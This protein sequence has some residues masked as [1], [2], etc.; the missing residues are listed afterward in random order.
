MMLASATRSPVA[1]GGSG[2]KKTIMLAKLGASRLSHSMDDTRECG[3]A[4]GADAGTTT[5]KSIMMSSASSKSFG[6]LMKKVCE[7]DPICGEN[8][9]INKRLNGDDGRKTL[10][11]QEE[12]ELDMVPILILAK[13]HKKYFPKGQQS[14]L[15]ADNENEQTN[16]GRVK[17]DKLKYIKQLQQHQ[18]KSYNFS[19]NTRKAIRLIEAANNSASGGGSDMSNNGRFVGKKSGNF[20]P[21][22]TESWLTKSMNSY[23]MNK[24]NSKL[25]QVCLFPLLDCLL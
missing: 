21:T 1:N 11:E 4:V 2:K 24:S 15:A 10:D 18:L 25:N 12:Q 9:S 16:G 20:S 6:N 13:Q 17:S 8:K 3:V 14:L 23:S 22:S 5:A 19:N 7:N